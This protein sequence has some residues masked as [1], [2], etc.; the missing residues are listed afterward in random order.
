ML[1]PDKVETKP[2]FC[3]K[4]PFHFLFCPASHQ[5]K[6]KFTN[7]VTHPR[8]VFLE[9]ELYVKK[10]MKNI[11]LLLPVSHV[12]GGPFPAPFS[13]PTRR[14]PLPSRPSK[15]P[16]PFPPLSSPCCA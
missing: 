7:T 8:T 5:I 4:Y 10:K 2:L 11:A 1:H 3:Q 14:P 12:R 9:S 16:L 6:S 15:C 13:P